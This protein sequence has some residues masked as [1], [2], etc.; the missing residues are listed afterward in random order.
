MKSDPR[1]VIVISKGKEI[2]K[3]IFDS[4]WKYR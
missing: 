2:D 1:S 3:E 4:I